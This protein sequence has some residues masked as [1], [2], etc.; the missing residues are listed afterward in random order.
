MKKLIIILLVISAPIQSAYSAIDKGVRIKD[1]CRLVGVRDNSLVGYGIV[2]G[3]AGTG[4]TSRSKATMQS[5][6][7]T[8]NKMGLKIKSEDVKSRNVAAVMVT[9]TL[10]PFAIRGDKIDVTVTSIGD[11]RS[12]LGGSLL[13]THL[14]AANG[15]IFAL[16]QGSLTIGGFK[17]DLNGNVAQKNH[18]TTGIIPDGAIVEEEIKTSFINSQSELVLKLKNPDFTTASR[19][20]TVLKKRFNGLNAKAI[21]A[22]NIRITLPSEYSNDSVAFIT[23]LEG[24]TIHPDSRARIVINERTGTVVSG[25][26]VS[27]SMITVS[28]GDI[29]LSIV[30]DFLVSQPSFVSRPSDNIQ[31]QVVSDTSIDVSEEIPV[32]L[33]LP[34]NTSVADLVTALRKV[35]TSSRDI[36][37][38]LQAIKRAGALHAELIIQ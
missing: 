23:K 1:L 33:S 4:D 8:L 21:D 3:L 6:T 12:L 35:K 14:K 10:P 7:N 37:T 11:A 5:I 27:I 32:N 19:I 13:L 31:T 36:I 9:S 26:D 34:E 2:A 38:I 20:S 17:Y 24:M 18:P 16:A 30:T 29:K 25:G 15:E 28:H 22:G